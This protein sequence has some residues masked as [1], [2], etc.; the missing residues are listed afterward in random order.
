MCRAQLGRLLTNKCFLLLS[1]VVT[2]TLASTAR[3]YHP[4]RS[5]T[6]KLVVPPR[7]SRCSVPSVFFFRL[8][9]CDCGVRKRKRDKVSTFV[10]PYVSGW[11]RARWASCWEHRWCRGLPRQHWWWPHSH[12]G[13]PAFWIPHLLFRPEPEPPP[14]LLLQ[15]LLLV[16]L[17]STHTHT[18]SRPGSRPLSIPLPWKGGSKTSKHGQVG[19]HA[20]PRVFPCAQVCFPVRQAWDE[21]SHFTDLG[22]SHTGCVM[23]K[24]HGNAKR[25]DTQR[26]NQNS[27]HQLWH[28]SATQTQENKFMKMLVETLKAGNW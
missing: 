18:H 7:N 12:M 14:L 5:T 11:R 13:P 4:A 23:N 20:L 26:P 21:S 3:R 27:S 16:L 10:C 6:N 15:L 17:Y 9:L 24:Q 2:L 8:C 19:V 25:W 22:P 1:E 28:H